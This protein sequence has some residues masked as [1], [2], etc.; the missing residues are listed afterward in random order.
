VS[1]R[2]RGVLRAGLRIW[3]KITSRNGMPSFPCFASLPLS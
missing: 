1:G 2:K 3:L